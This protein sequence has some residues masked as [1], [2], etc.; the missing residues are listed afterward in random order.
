[1]NFALILAGGLGTRMGDTKKPKQFLNLGNKP[2]LIH[3]IEKFSINNKIDQI[4]VLTAKEWINFAKDLINTYIPH[5]DITVIEG[6]E[7]RIETIN[8]GMEYIINNYGKNDDHII[9]THD[10][11]RPFI[12]H[13]VIMENI[14]KTKKYGACN[15]VIPS[16]DTIVESKNK[17]EV[18]NIPNREKMYQGQTPQSF[19]LTKLK[20]FYDKLTHEEKVKLSDACKIYILNNEPVYLV[21]G[22]VS[23]IKITYSYDLKVANYILKEDNN[24]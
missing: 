16:T 7:L 14:K 18:S 15:T 17:K 22:E 12:T 5:N 20:K 1:M 23:N 9:I 3:T 11:V 24:D 13:R 6:G 2:I 8:N 19:K 10:A 21:K 4:I